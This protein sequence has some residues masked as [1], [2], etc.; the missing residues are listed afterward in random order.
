[1]KILAREVS[2]PSLKAYHELKQSGAISDL[3]D[4][5]YRTIQQFYESNGY[6]PTTREAHAF[7]VLEQEHQVAQIKG[8][9]DIRRRLSE[10]V[11]DPDDNNPDLLEKCETREQVYL[12]KMVEEISSTKDAQPLK[13]Q[14]YE[15]EDN[16][17]SEDV[18]YRSQ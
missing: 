9:E 3:Q 13:I 7:L 10:L 6:W 11:V 17:E 2:K 14:G 18:I 1:V 15:D 12:V 4:L 5:A 16:G 8:P